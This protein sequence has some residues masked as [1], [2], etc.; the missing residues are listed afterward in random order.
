MEKLPT[1]LAERFAS[2]FTKEEMSDLETVFSL[3]SRPVSF[4]LNTLISTPE[5]VEEGLSKA[6]I[7]YSK[8]DFPL[9]SYVIDE[10]FI[11]SDIWKRRVYKDGH[12]YMQ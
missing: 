2:I 12:I 4:R 6:S 9:N 10:G 11:E 1:Q 3:E 8:L 7:T 5:E